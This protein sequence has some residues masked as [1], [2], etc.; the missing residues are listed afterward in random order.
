MLPLDGPRYLFDTSS[1]RRVDELQ[2]EQAQIEQIWAEL[3]SMV[4]GGRALTVEPV[5]DELERGAPDVYDRLK[6]YRRT[7]FLITMRAQLARGDAA[8]VQE[9]CRRFPKLCQGSQHNRTV[10]DPW[11]IAAAYTENLT[12]VTEEGRGEQ[13]IP[14]VCEWRGVPCIALLDLVVREGL[15]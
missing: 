12:V 2:V 11:L 15:G 3:L 13:K 8:I 14:K 1:L 9:L 7:P 10:A 5:Y 6:P 4:D